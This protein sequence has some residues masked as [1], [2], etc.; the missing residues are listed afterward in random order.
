MRTLA[1]I[2]VLAP[3]TIAFET[4]SDPALTSAEVSHYC[5]DPAT[6]ATAHG[7]KHE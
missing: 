4:Y 6:P 3:I 7:L 2:F 1:V 5:P